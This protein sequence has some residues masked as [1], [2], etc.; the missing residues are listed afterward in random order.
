MFFFQIYQKLKS[1]NSFTQKAFVIFYL[2]AYK[3]YYFMQE[4]SW[5]SQNGEKLVI[6]IQGK[7][8]ISHSPCEPWIYAGFGK[9]EFEMYR[10]NFK[11]KENLEEKMGLR[12]YKIENSDSEK[13]DVTFSRGGLFS[14]KVRFIIS[15]E[16]GLKIEFKEQQPKEINR[17]WLRIKAEEDEHIYGCGEQ[18]SYF[19]LRGKNF[20]LWT[21]EQG[22][23]RNKNT[24][25]TFL[26]DSQDQAGGDYYST[27]FPQPTFISSRKYY[28]HVDDS[29]YMDFN[30]TRKEYHELEIWNIP[31]EVRFESASTFTALLGRLTQ[32]LGR[33]SE[34]PKWVYEGV[35]LGMQ[36]GTSLV[37]KKLQNALEKGLKV[38]GI[39]CQDWQGIRFTSFGKRLMWNW[40]WDKELY[41]GLDKEIQNLKEKGIRFLGYINPYLASEKPLFKEASLKGFL[42]KNQK[43]EDYLVDFGEFYAGIVDFT[44]PE[45]SRWYKDFVIKKNL[46]DFGLSGWMADFG[47][48]LPIDVV[49]HSGASAELLHNAWPAIWAQINYEAVQEAGK[50]GEVVFFMRAGFTGS[51]KYSTLMWAGDQ[52]VDWSLDDGLASVIPAALSLGMSGVGLHHSDIGGYTTLFHMKRTKELFMRWAEMGAFTPVMRTHEGNRPGDNWQFDSDEETLLHFARMSSIYRSLSPYLQFVVE[53][54]SKSGIPVQ[55]PLFLH[56]ENDETAYTLKYQYLLGADILVAPVYTE[57]V[58]EWEVYLPED[59]W[60]HFWTGDNHNGGKAT[61]QA[62]LGKP[63][64][65]YRKKSEFAQLFISVSKVVE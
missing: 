5:L 13:M 57:N 1:L 65:F 40:E 11:I 2:I 31:K 23:G 39:W 48:Y 14:I 29:A 54:Y 28:C 46:I 56:Y 3:Y 19:D 50:I 55:R 44:N 38:S 15:S 21:S 34:L 49:L 62:P 17:V 36:G 41:P 18:F 59:E 20:P 52:N 45:A 22:V 30:F 10:G 47:E 27:F 4:N 16:E 26:A 53:E 12:D 9:A 32:S 63:P 7:E 6:K 33:V 8:I 58:S 61:V 35:W 37:L 25:V 64:V 24:Y 60:V 42:A 51:S 43:G